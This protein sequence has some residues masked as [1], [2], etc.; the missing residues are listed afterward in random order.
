MGVIMVYKPTYNW[1]AHPVEFH[2]NSTCR[3]APLY[4]TSH[5]FSNITLRSVHGGINN[6]ATGKYHSH[7]RILGMILDTDTEILL[8]CQNWMYK[9]QEVLF[10]K[11]RL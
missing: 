9:H 5:G 1:G 6:D 4:T 3:H 7:W 11:M 10:C 8:N 2:R